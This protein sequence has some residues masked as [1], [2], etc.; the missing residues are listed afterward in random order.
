MPK[1]RSVALMA[2][3][4]P[5]IVAVPVPAA[6]TVAPPAA[7]T[8]SVPCCT[9]RVVVSTPPLESLSAIDNPSMKTLPVI[10]A[11][12]GLVG[13]VFTG[14]AFSPLMASVSTPVLSVG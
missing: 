11:L 2:H 3:T 10:A 12:S 6:A 7:E 8:S 9:E 1:A 4:V 5:V 14:A 13:T